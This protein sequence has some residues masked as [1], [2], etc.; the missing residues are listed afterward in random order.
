MDSFR[1]TVFT[2]CYNSE[3]FIHRVFNSLS[4]QTFRNF[5]WYV[6]NDASTDS[7]HQLIKEYIKNVDFNVN[8][9]NLEK[10]QGIL[11]NY[12]Y[13]I[14][15]SKGQFLVP[16]G[17]DD[18]MVPEALEVFNDV[19]IKFD[20]PEISA[21]YALAMDQ[22]GK[23]IGKKYSQDELISDYWTQF[24]AMR[25]EAE[26]FQCFKVEYLR[27]FY[28]INTSSENGLTSAWLWGMLRT[29]YKAVFINKVL[30]IYYT[31]VPTSITNTMKRDKNPR[32]VFNYYQYWVNEFQYYIKG[33]Y[34]RRLQGIGGFVSYGLLS[35]ITVKNLL[36]RA[37]KIGNKIWVVLFIPI[38]KLY[39]YY[40]KLKKINCLTIKL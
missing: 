37:A 14:K 27:E 32:P 39:N 17:H 6:I 21:I 33:N 26:K 9:I 13:A 23:L 36:E 29:K 4:K 10:N 1:F 24:F 34:L 30:R 28:P 22:N 12:N 11:A 19:L 15:D 25:N 7:T 18:E 20:S 5:E 16:F 40:Y 2:P 31:N 38:A 3:S 8:Y 35:G